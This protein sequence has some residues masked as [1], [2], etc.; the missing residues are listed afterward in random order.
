VFAETLVISPKRAKT[1]NNFFIF[2][3]FLEIELLNFDVK[4][5]KK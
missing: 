2:I 4:Y 5:K 3:I 1:R